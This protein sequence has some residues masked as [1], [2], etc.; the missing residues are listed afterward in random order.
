MCEER[1]KKGEKGEK[2]QRVKIVL[3]ARMQKKKLG[4]VAGMDQLLECRLKS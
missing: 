3:L 4:V 1:E 2:E